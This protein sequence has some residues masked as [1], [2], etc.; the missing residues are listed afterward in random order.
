M[1]KWEEE[2]RLKEH[3]KLNIQWKLQLDVHAQIESNTGFHPKS[4]LVGKPMS[5]SLHRNA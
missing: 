4:S 1:S 3:L 2:Y 5:H